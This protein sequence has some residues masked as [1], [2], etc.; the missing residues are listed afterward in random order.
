M[1]IKASSSRRPR[2][3]SSSTKLLPKGLPFFNGIIKKKGM[4]NLVFY[5]YLAAAWPRPSRPSTSSRSSGFTQATQAGFSL[6]ID[7]FVIPKNKAELVDKAAEEVQEIEKLY[8][9]GTISAA[10]GSTTIIKSGRR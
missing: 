6:G 1:T 5:I 4:E 3:G 10:S 8:L 9:D 2:A 7:D